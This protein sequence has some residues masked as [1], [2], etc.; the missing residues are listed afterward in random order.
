[1]EPDFED[2][3]L[4]ILMGTLEFAAEVDAQVDAARQVQAVWDQVP[5]QLRTIIGKRVAGIRLTKAEQSVLR[6]FR[7]RLAGISSRGR[8]LVTGLGM[9]KAA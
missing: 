7:Q 2:T 9:E 5:P 8:P 3:Y 4:A 1:M 6:R